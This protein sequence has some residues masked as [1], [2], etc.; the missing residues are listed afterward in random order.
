MMPN[1]PEKTVEKQTF[2]HE[3]TGK[4]SLLVVQ[5]RLNAGRSGHEGLR[6][7]FSKIN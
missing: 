5:T 3:M 2:G 6:H 4:Y 1:P 7:F